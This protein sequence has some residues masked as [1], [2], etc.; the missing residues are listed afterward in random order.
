M[1]FGHRTGQQTT[2]GA[3]RGRVLAAVAPAM[4]L[5]LLI[6][7]GSPVQA[8]RSLTEQLHTP[9]V[10]SLRQQRDVA[11]E[12]LL[13]GQDH[14][15][16]GDHAAAITA[17]QEAANAYHYLGDFVG[18]GEAYEQLVKVYSALGQYDDAER[19]I[20]Q[21]L[22]IAR[23]DQN[24][25]DQIR[26]LNNLGT[27]HLQTGDLATAHAAFL[28]GLTVSQDVDSNEGI[29]LSL[30]NLG[31]VAAAQGQL[32]DARKYYE[33]A[34]E[35][36]VRA[37]DFAGQ[38][39]TD[40]NL[41]DVYLAGGQVRQAIGAYRVALSVAKNINEPYLQLRALD[42]LIEIYRDRNEP[43]ELSRYLNERIALTQQTGDDWQQLLTLQTIGEIHQD[44]GDWAAA[45]DAF[46]R[47]L[48]LAR[49][50]DRKQVQAELTNRL[51]WLS[52]Q[53]ND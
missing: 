29:G 1:G 38:S 28:E 50:M 32:N 30:S 7:V 20:R 11:D 16:L 41:G 9:P 49:T 53:L 26:A 47:A 18:M 40:S 39:N 27:I 6:A 22:A 31:L 33:V 37:R 14:L 36:R 25:S 4:T 48:N 44:Q 24:F 23:S 46:S 21:Q 13:L 17:L 45:Q 42:G 43:S 15:R 51:L 19:V 35:Y 12:F 5:L 2:L 52:S 34:I 8:A 10:D 3:L